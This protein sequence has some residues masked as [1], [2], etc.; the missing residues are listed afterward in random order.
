MTIIFKCG[1]PNGLKYQSF[2]RLITFKTILD[3]NIYIYI[4]P[5]LTHSRVFSPDVHT[6][7]NNINGFFV[8]HLQRLFPNAYAC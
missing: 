8:K 3:Y 4:K 1:V 2:K 7:I 5:P 6:A